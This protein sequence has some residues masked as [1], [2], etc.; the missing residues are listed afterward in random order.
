MSGSPMKR[1]LPLVLAVLVL[2]GVAVGTASLPRLRRERLAL[3]R[4]QG[5]MER[6]AAP[7]EPLLTDDRWLAL[8]MRWVGLRMPGHAVSLAITVRD[9]ENLPPG[10]EA[11]LVARPQDALLRSLQ[12]GG[13][14]LT[15]E[16]PDGLGVSWDETGDG[17]ALCGHA[18]V[19]IFFVLPPGSA[20]TIPSKP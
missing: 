9:V 14:T 13:Y 18:G 10:R 20:G 19:R 5:H 2:T 17:T 16:T 6:S 11:V 15:P 7:D 4:L 1:N 3:V 12:S 8:G